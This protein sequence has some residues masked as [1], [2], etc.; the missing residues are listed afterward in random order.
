M[1]VDIRRAVGVVLL[2]V[3]ASTAAAE[4]VLVE[5]ILIRVNDRIVT[6]S[7]F[8]ERMMVELS[9]D[10]NPPSTPDAVRR[11]AERIF[12]ALLEEMIL[13]ER[14]DEMGITVE[15]EA[16]DQY[17][18]SIREEN[19]L[20]DDEAFRQAL[21]QMDMTEDSL[22]ARFREQILLNR[23]ARSE[24]SEPEITSEEVRRRY[25]RDLER[26][27]TPAQVEL[28]QVVFPVAADGSDRAAV[29]ARV[30]ALVERVRG[31]S[32][33]TAEST[34]AGVEVLETGAIPVD[35]LWPELREAVEGLEE[36]QISEAIERGAGLLVVRLV[37]RI[38]A[39]HVPFEEVR[40]NVRQQLM[41]EAYQEQTQGM[42]ER[43]KE[44]YL[45]EVHR[46]RLDTLLANL[47]GA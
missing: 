2:V 35:D 9:Q 33:L 37:R 22:R 36:G 42:V 1:K 15:D 44:E 7:D 25:E 14:A 31:G 17:V 20:Q 21:E 45:V 18:A 13:L 38:P 3:A 11:Y 46:D 29:E 12:D 23:A 10:R 41:I 24:V 30:R 6:L 27:A 5:A 47:P 40:D 34:L 16:V 39:G 19:Q 32:D 4:R 28:E 43:L 8:S 26:F